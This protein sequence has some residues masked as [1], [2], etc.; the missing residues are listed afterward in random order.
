MSKILNV[1]VENTTIDLYNGE[2][3]E[4]DTAKL[5]F[6]P[7][8]NAEV[9]VFKSQEKTIVRKIEKLNIHTL[10]ETSE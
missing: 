1:N 8:V 5:D 6:I 2:I 7:N 9:E 4:I 10:M 3:L